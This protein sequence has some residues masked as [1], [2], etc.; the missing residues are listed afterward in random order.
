MDGAFHR[1]LQSKMKLI[2]AMDSMCTPAPTPSSCWSPNP[3]IAILEKQ[4]LRRWLQLNEVGKVEPWSDRTT[5]VLIEREETPK[6]P[7]SVP[8]ELARGSLKARKGVLSRNQSLMQPES[9]MLQSPEPWEN[10]F[11]SFKP[12]SLRD[13]AVA[14]LADWDGNSRYGIQV[15]PTSLGK[16]GSLLKAKWHDTNLL[17]AHFWKV[18]DSPHFMPFWLLKG[19][20]GML[21]SCSSVSTGHYF[22]DPHRYK[23]L[24]MLMSLL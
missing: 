17:K 21:C 12:P 15:S 20:F 24:S 14:A 23:T 6:I 9:W 5:G 22:Q 3:L 8:K 10:Q 19:F 7:L 2:T 16:L 4:P 11:L 1:S 18:E 13:C